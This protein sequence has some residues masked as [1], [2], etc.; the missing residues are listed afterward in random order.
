VTG[1]VAFCGHLGPTTSARSC[2]MNV[3][4]STR[5]VITLTHAP[6]AGW[7]AAKEMDSC[8]CLQAPTAPAQTIQQQ[9]AAKMP[10]TH[11]LKAARSTPACPEPHHSSPSYKA[12]PYSSTQN[13]TMY[14][15]AIAQ[16]HPAAA[17][18][19]STPKSHQRHRTNKCCLLSPEQMRTPLHPG[20]C[21][22]P[23]AKALLRKTFHISAQGCCPQ[24]FQ[25]SSP[26]T[27]FTIPGRI[28]PHLKAKMLQSTRRDPGAHSTAQ[29]QGRIGVDP[30]HSIKGT[31]A[32]NLPIASS[33]SVPVHKISSKSRSLERTAYRTRRKNMY[34]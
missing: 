2:S 8:C 21:K 7:A 30:E 29:T 26:P 28:M 12:S 1:A 24:C 20:S 32:H 17:S 27:N 11:A 34:S 13:I 23:E 14:L 10:H 22:P 15:V 18:N 4:S 16:S 5:I 19:Q 3:E 33:S 9:T 31:M 6:A 25:S